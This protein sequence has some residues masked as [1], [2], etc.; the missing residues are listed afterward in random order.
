MRAGDSCR[1]VAFFCILAVSVTGQSPVRLKVTAHITAHLENN[2]DVECRTENWCGTRDQSR[3]LEGFSIKLP[4]RRPGDIGLKYKC[5]IQ[6]L[7]DTEP[8]P[9]GEFCGTRGQSKG[10]EGFAI[11][12]EGGDANRFTVA[13]QAWL[14]DLGATG[15]YRD[16]QFAGTRNPSRRLEALRVWV[17]PRK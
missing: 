17:E 11:W 15:V 4:P 8:K 3:K 1:A 10:L 16:G 14:H 12:L 2:G 5:H 9:E 7:G 13:Y 6:D